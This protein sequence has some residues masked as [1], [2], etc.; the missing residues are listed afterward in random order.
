MIDA[1]VTRS[2]KDANPALL[3]L[4]LQ[5]WWN[6]TTA[7]AMGEAGSRQTMTVGSG[8]SINALDPAQLTPGDLGI[9]EHG[10]HIMAY[11]GN[12]EWIEAD[13]TIGR[14]VRMTPPV[15]DNGW[16]ASPVVVARWQILGR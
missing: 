5:T 3:R 9:V 8:A 4:A 14:V 1:M 6:D 11:L 12:G 16:F 7:R 15:K 10:L 13:P 2:V